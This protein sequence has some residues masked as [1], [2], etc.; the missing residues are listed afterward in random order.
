LSLIYKRE[1][2]DDVEAVLFNPAPSHYD[3]L[4][5]VGFLFYAG[6]TSL[7]VCD[8]IYDLNE[9]DKYDEKT[10]YN[11]V[12]SIAKTFKGKKRHWRLEQLPE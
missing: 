3:R 1:K 12:M 7:Q 2:R 8:L 10:T 6:Y 11:Q 9:W 4:W 5:M